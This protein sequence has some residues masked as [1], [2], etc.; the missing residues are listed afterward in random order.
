MSTSNNSRRSLSRRSLSKTVKHLFM[1]KN[2]ITKELEETLNKADQK[3]Q[4]E[5]KEKADREELQ[6]KINNYREYLR[7]AEIQQKEMEE[8]REKKRLEEVE[9]HE[10]RDRAFYNLLTSGVEQF[11]YRS[12][13]LNKQPKLN[14]K[15]K[16]GYDYFRNHDFSSTGGSRSKKRT[17]RS[18]TKTRKTKNL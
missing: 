7:K 14:P 11:N 15:D 5:E 1:S 16:P 9:E 10:R 6:K 12:E 4:Q 2:Q 3:K 17:R 13:E 8:Q 18:K